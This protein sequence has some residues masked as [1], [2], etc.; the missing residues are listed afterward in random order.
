MAQ[1]VRTICYDAQLHLEAYR[2]EGVI[3]AFPNHFHDYY[4]IGLLEAGC[5]RLS[6]KNREYAIGPGD[7]LLFNP[8]DSHGCVQ[9]DEGSLDY[10]GINIPENTMASLAEEITGQQTFPSFS[11]TVIRD[12]EIGRYLTALHS[13]I[14]E[15]AEGFE[16]EELLL[17]LLSSLL[18]RYGQPFSQ[19]LM[20]YNKETDAACAF[21]E[22]HFGERITLEQL[23]NA[24]HLSKSTLLRAFTKTK[25]VTPYRYLQAIRIG[26]A[27]ALLEQ[28]VLPIDSA[29]QTGFSDQ[30]HFTNAF[31]S[32]I[33]LS[34]AAYR[35]IF[36]EKRKE[37]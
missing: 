14:L 20:E 26:K 4:V 11:E 35:R 8:H 32:F 23:C 2:F 3:Q 19:V 10:R 25:G 12:T 36:Q 21:M 28:G 1:E 27:K 34:P 24:S 30:S 37:T 16:K 17:L 33:G 6:C 31:H 13:M 29:S 18:A 15:G 7:I 9:A 22:H 5:R